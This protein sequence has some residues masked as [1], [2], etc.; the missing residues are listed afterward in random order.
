MDGSPSSLRIVLVL[1]VM[2]SLFLLF[3]VTGS[4]GQTVTTSITESGLGTTIQHPAGSSTTN[5]RG[6][7]L[8]TG[9]TNSNLFHSFGDFSIASGQTALFQNLDG[10]GTAPLLSAPS[11]VSNIIGRVTGSNPSNIY[12]TVNT[13]SG[14]SNASLFLINPNGI[15][16]GPNASFT[17]GGS[18]HLSTA[19]YLRL[20]SSNNRF[21]ADLG[22]TSQ[23]TSAP[24]TAF[25]F[26]N[27][28]PAAIAV[29][30]SNLVVPNAQT[31]SLIGGNRTFPDPDNPSVNVPSGVT[32][33]GGALSAPSGQINLASV[34]SPGEV[35]INAPGETP[36]LN[37][38][39]F[40][41]LGDIKVQQ[42]AN[43]DVSGGVGGVAGGTVLIRG[44]QLTLDGSSIAAKTLGSVDGASPGIDIQVSGDVT[45]KNNSV[46]ATGTSSAGKAGNVSIAGATLSMDSGATIS[47]SADPG[48]TGAGGAAGA[49]AINVDQLTVSN[50]G[51]ISSTSL[52]SFASTGSAGQIQIQGQ[53]GKGSFAQTVTLDNGTINT[54]ANAGQ[55]GTIEIK[56]STIDLR[57]DSRVLAT[58]QGSNNAG[59]IT[60]TSNDN[61][62]ITNSTVKTFAGQA[63]GGD[64]TLTAPL[65]SLNDKA[66]VT[67]TPIHVEANELRLESAANI[68]ATSSGAGN[69]GDILI[70][71]A[72]LSLNSGSEISADSIGNG[73]PG[74][75]QIITD[76]MTVSG[77]G[78]KVATGADASGSA[79]AIAIN[80]A[81]LTVSNGGSIS[82]TSVGSLASAGSAGQIQIQG[83]SRK[84]SFAQTVTLDKGTINT[85]ASAGQGGT[86]EIKASNIDLR[87][88]SRVLATAQ[89]SNNAGDITVTSND[90]IV[91]TNSTVK[92]SAGQASGGNI[93]LTAP[94]MVRLVGATLTSSVFGSATTQGGN[95]TIN[96]AHPQFVIMQDNSQIL[97]KANEG[98]GGA[99]RI[100]AGV[101][102]LE[103]GT[104]LDATAGPAGINGTINIQAPIQ[105]LS[106]AI[107]PLP[108]A[109]AV[110]TNLYG[111]H[112]AAEK[113][114]QF[115]S[116]VQGARDGVPPQPGD[117]IPSPLQFDFNETT[118]SFVPK[119]SAVSAD[120]A[121]LQMTQGTDA[122]VSTRHVSP[123]Y[124]PRWP[125]N[126]APVFQLSDPCR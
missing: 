6:G 119:R 95:I 90:N 41:R 125:M 63:S 126:L 78:S 66:V 58:T 117:L 86:I 65:V 108:Q 4:E 40:A 1:M 96:E 67:G 8:V 114:G 43:I 16:V 21:Y 87:N 80:V 79:G 20:G 77:P 71:A 112:C 115:S 69:T 12:G 94:N 14:F 62:V 23:L 97:A 64:I 91:I 28:N 88:D 93:D 106:G 121:Y 85:S 2:T 37:V 89:R 24:V 102:L 110:A 31:L 99:I 111:Q 83:Q 105:Q 18:L 103:P 30:G 10:A 9:T 107:A 116:F 45:L 5:I 109:F 101:V 120:I 56:A 29:K 59:D 123:T 73:N 25:G 72:S 27:S 61:I 113:G 19:E 44:G 46:L 75:I 11:T 100:N 32:M 22:K 92:T 122:L 74:T 36:S 68:K 55:G 104:V 50:G 26:L 81:Q 118:T 54:S 47:A 52:G 76:H 34:A 124:I 60:L 84:G 7:T 39:S 51:S 17:L 49:I 15:V 57:N 98:Q 35:V 82:S 70:S 48:P 38:N 53:S 33:T 42:A 3:S 13:Q